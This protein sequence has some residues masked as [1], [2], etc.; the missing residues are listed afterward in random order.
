MLKKPTS[1]AS[2]TLLKMSVRI[3]LVVILMASLSYFH[4]VGLLEDQTLDKLLNYISERSERESEIFL[5]AE[6]N[7]KIFRDEFL[8][9]WQIRK[10]VDA[11]ARFQQ[12]FYQPGDGTTRLKPEIYDGYQ[13]PFKDPAANM[14]EGDHISGFVGRGAPVESN[15]YRNRLLLGF[16]LVDQFSEAWENRF[17]NTYVSTPEGSN[18]VHWPGVNWGKG[19]EATLDIPAEEWVYIANKKNNPLRQSVWTGLYYDQTANEW[20]VSCETPVDDADGRHLIN[21][22][23]DI[24]LNSLFDRVFNDRIQGTYNFIFREDGRL[25]AHPDFIQQLRDAKGLLNISELGSK[26]MA[27]HYR[28]ILQIHRSTGKNAFILDDNQPG[29]DDF[30]AVSRIKGPGWFFVTVYPKSLMATPAKSAALFILM[31]GICSLLLELALLFMVLRKQIIQ[32]LQEFETASGFIIDG[33]LDLQSNPR[34]DLPVSRA[35]EVGRL[36]KAMLLMSS[37]INAYSAELENRVKQRTQELEESNERLNR[38]FESSPDPVWII[39]DNSFISCNQAAVKQLGYESV[40]QLMN[41]HPSILSPPKQ[42][43]GEDSFSKA[44]RMMSIAYA[45]GVNRFEW[46]HSRADGS[47]FDAEVTLSRLDL[48][49]KP[50]LYCI[51]RD[52]TERKRTEVELQNYRQ[53]LETLVAARTKELEKAKLEAEHASQAK[54]EFLANMSHEIRTPMNAVIGMTYLAMQAGLSEKQHHFVETA[55]DAAENLLGIINAILDFSKIEAGKLSLE[56]APFQLDKLLN[57][58]IEMQT[59]LLKDRQISLHLQKADDIPGKLI[60]DSLRLGQV[61]TNL[62]NNAIKFSHQHGVIK[63]QV[64]KQEQIGDNI[65]LSF[66]VE[67]QGIGISAE[68]QKRLFSAFT[69][70]DSSNTRQYGG[71]GL[72][73]VISESLVELMDGE[74][75]LHSEEGKGS[76]F[77]FSVMLQ[78]DRS[79]LPALDENAHQDMQEVMPVL[80]DARVLLVEDNEINQELVLE[81][82]ASAGCLVQT[83]FDGQQA[84][85]I[86]EREAFDLVLMDCQMPVMDGFE[87]TRRIRFNPALVDLPILALTAN[88][89]KDDVEKVMRAGMNDHIPK[90]ID[91]DQMFRLIAKWLA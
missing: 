38:L 32:P 19:A 53:N 75:I 31:L 49:G 25:I 41:T 84:L 63:L 10:D 60:G 62:L 4:I 45:R 2:V 65:R 5:L 50:H 73:L 78:Q 83:A 74:I 33:N 90:P 69:Q 67:D 12:L 66:A 52:I 85:D 37:K 89:M 79:V 14:R 23:H 81:L 21:I 20:M 54:S 43:D 29:H 88:V 6:D 27:D 80:K 39:G 86:L 59:I 40:E 8:Y 42:P 28:E 7:H 91:P 76:R 56:K 3:T 68:Q 64:N 48:E 15:E 58:V 71:T 26:N 24:L 44:E 11:T 1:L 17:A 57:S 36:A 46:V 77:E 51:W 22:G 47:V 9:L 87:T 18:I 16:D 70:A 82:L 61:I 34:V 55:H 13:R 72:G 30:L 35:D